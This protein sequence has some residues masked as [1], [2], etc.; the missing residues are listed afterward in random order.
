MCKT[1]MEVILI[2]CSLFFATL[3]L[4]MILTVKTLS[5][6]NATLKSRNIEL[7]YNA[8]VYNNLAQKYY[9][10]YMRLNKAIPVK[11]S[12][13]TSVSWRVVMGFAKNTPLTKEQITTR[14]KKLAMVHHPD[15]NGGSN[16]GMQLLNLAK[17]K[18]DLEFK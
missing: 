18:A 12:S 13:E 16:Y 2:F 3:A 17:E 8:Q 14:Y 6:E 9:A 5:S 10:A 11:A 4:T 1:T 7:T 15:Q